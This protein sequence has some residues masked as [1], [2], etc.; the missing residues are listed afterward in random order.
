MGIENVRMLPKTAE[1]GA[2]HPFKRHLHPTHVGALS[3]EP[4]DSSPTAYA[5]KVD[6]LKLRLA[7]TLRMCPH[8]TRTVAAMDSC[9]DLVRL[10]QHDIAVG[11]QIGLKTLFYFVFKLQG[12]L[13][14]FP[15]ICQ[16]NNN[17]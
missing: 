8:I 14:T 16:N 15:D 13:A 9:F 12:L 3:W 7:S 1:A 6:Q 2:K 5:E 17:N 11:Q 4:H 10:H